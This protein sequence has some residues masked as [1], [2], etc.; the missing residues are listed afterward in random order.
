MPHP[1]MVLDVDEC[2]LSSLIQGKNTAI[3][4]TSQSPMS[5]FMMS[6]FGL[7]LR[8]DPDHLE[9]F[10]VA[11]NGADERTGDTT[12]QDRKQEFLSELRKLKWAGRDMPITVNRVWS[13]LGHGQSLDACVSWVHTE[14]YTIMHDDVILQDKGWGDL[15]TRRLS[16]PHTALAF[17][18][19][20]LACG[21]EKNMHEG[22]WKL[23]F[24]HLNSTFVVCKKALTSKAGVRWA[25]YHFQN[26]F[27]LY[28]MVD[29]KSFLAHHTGRKHL[30]SF[31][32]I[33][34]PYSLVSMDV[35]AWMYYELG[36]MGYSFAPLPEDILCHFISISWHTEDQI[37]KK[38]DRH[39]TV[40]DRLEADLAEV[41]E[42]YALYRKYLKG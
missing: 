2:E 28:D 20:L 30:R 22:R 12:L 26:P 18:P 5:I 41:P 14:F 19:P 38:M 24:P 36:N 15:A 29:I 7:L 6:I 37:R 3:I 4:A 9:H 13:R 23:N 34:R 25:G 32:V 40:I 33:E 11:I 39:R 31:P 10:M 16:D 1:H 21:M 27:H 17:H 8:S 42:Y 35:G